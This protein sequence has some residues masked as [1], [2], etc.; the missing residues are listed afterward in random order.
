[1]KE[2]LRNVL[3]LPVKTPIEYWCRY[4]RHYIERLEDK[5]EHDVGL[6]GPRLVLENVMSEVIY[7]N[8]S[9]EKNA[10]FYGE[11]INHWNKRDAAFNELYGDKVKLLYDKYCATYK[12]YVLVVCQDIIED[13]NKG[14]YF[15]T[16]TLCLIN[17]LKKESVDYE[18]KESINIYTE[19][20]ITEFVS[21]GFS[22]NS[23]QSIQ[24]HPHDIFIIEGGDIIA[25]P[26][27]YREL[28]RDNYNNSE[29]YYNAIRLRLD[30]RTI[31]ER[32]DEIKGYFHNE[33][34]D[35]TVLVAISGIKNDIDVTIGGIN[36]YSPTKKKYIKEEHALSEIEKCEKENKK[37]IAAVPIR[38]K[39]AASA[40]DNACR[41]L[42]DF[43][44]CLTLY[45]NPSV[46]FTYNRSDIA[47]V[48]EGRVVMAS[49]IGIPDA[50][51]ELDRKA[52]IDFEESIPSVEIEKHI[53]DLK[54]RFSVKPSDENTWNQLTTAIYWHK[55]G[56]ETDKAEDKLLYSWIA[57]ESIVKVDT[58]TIN[59]ITHQKKSY[60][61]DAIQKICKAALIP[62][63]FYNSWYRMYMQLY[64]TILYNDNFYD[65]P[66]DVIIKAGLNREFGEKISRADFIN[67]IQ[68]IENGVNDE[69]I[70]TK[71]H[72][73]YLLYNNR[74]EINKVAKD[75]Y[76]DV[77]QIYRLRNLIVHNAV[78]PHNII[79][80]Y[81]RKASYICGNVINKMQA[82]Y[83]QTSMNMKYLLLD[84]SARYD[85]FHMGLDKIIQSFKTK[86]E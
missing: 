33:E 71:L 64:S 23:I 10:K 70:K 4:W 55:K 37:I 78:Y 22:L 65:I 48:K 67:N 21:C 80:L 85:E 81:A 41:K 44:G 11:E 2:H 63:T 20:I 83:A 74:D 3:G 24:S 47:V 73:L 27:T 16:L 38:C 32:I 59:M 69:I 13:M 19:L 15:D 34:S 26:S 30:R 14:S 29:E 60:K 18:T 1:M 62:Y 5:K 72:H 77:L 9:N 84:L 61:I 35:Y 36:L 50:H 7:N 82:G 49:T 8:L 57:I 52:Y 56:V 54:E 42:N 28:K 6:V 51:K 66:D 40:I 79:D 68:A 53:E 31:E 12:D 39:I 17:E 46:P 58:P 43:L 86:K 45:Y 75:L 76:G 25:A